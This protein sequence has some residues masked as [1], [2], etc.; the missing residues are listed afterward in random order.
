MRQII[1][2]PDFLKG[3]P[4]VGGVRL[5][6]DLILDELSQKKNIREVAKKFPQLTEDDVIFALQYAIKVVN[7]HPEEA[8]IVRDSRQHDA[9]P[10]DKPASAHLDI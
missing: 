7:K 6:V 1:C 5:S 2:D 8:D 4:Y 3:K 9:D 10:A